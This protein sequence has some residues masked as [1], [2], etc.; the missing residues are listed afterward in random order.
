MPEPLPGSEYMSIMPL[1]ALT[2]LWMFFQS[3]T[4]GFILWLFRYL[5]VQVFT[6]YL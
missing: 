4:F 3:D 5:E 6:I 1:P 2:R